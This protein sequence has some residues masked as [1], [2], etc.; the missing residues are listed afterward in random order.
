MSVSH[1]VQTLVVTL[2][3]EWEL[4]SEDPFIFCYRIGVEPVCVFFAR[5][6]LFQKIQPVQVTG[7]DDR[8]DRELRTFSIQR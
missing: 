1:L 3:M 4:C 8:I 5:A 6:G 7:T 2:A